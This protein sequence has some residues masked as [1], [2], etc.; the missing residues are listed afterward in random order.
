MGLRPSIFVDAGA[1][2]STNRPTLDDRTTA[3]VRPLLN[4]AR[5]FQCSAASG[6]VVASAPQTCPV[7]HPTPVAYTLPPLRDFYFVNT[8]KPRLSVGL[9]FHCNYSFWPL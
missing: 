4:S 2:W 6:G 9:C 3:T 7:S 5:Q 8:P 1:L